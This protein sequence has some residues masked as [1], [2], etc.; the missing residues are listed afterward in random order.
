MIQ[1]LL[2]SYC[3][4]AARMARRVG[5][6]YSTVALASRYRR[7]RS[8]WSAHLRLS[9]ETILEHLPA[10]A[11]SVLIIGSGLLLEIPMAELL[12][13]KDVKI[14]LL[15]IV[16]P[17]R[18]RWLARRYPGR[19]QLIEQDITGCLQ[20]FSQ[21]LSPLKNLDFEPAAEKIPR[22]DYIVSANL[23]SQ[24]PLDPI[25]RLRRLKQ[26]WADEKFFKLLAQK[27]GDQHISLLTKQESK[28]LLIADTRR[29]YF[30]K[31]HEKIETSPSA[32]ICDK[33]RFVKKW[34]WLIS[35]LGETSKEF[36]YSMVVE[37][38]LL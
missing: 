14:F 28:V 4:P 15:D 3:T 6:V 30:N 20:F 27:M 10:D 9:R 23:L 7:C 37:A 21:G 16:H 38:R 13:K 19:I 25:E 34:N 1:E 8:A 2:L 18:V 12:K 31:N 36:Y 33:G 26:D 32:Y 29:E 22:V 24:L 11:K 17:L 35:P 5:Y